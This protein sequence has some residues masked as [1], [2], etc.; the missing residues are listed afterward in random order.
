[1]NKTHSFSPDQGFDHYINVM[2]PCD[3][4]IGKDAAHSYKTL[5]DDNTVGF[6]ADSILE[7]SSGEIKHYKREINQC[8]S[9]SN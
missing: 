2:R 9:Q 4:L 8:N 3:A 5:Y 1:M 7:L 6:T